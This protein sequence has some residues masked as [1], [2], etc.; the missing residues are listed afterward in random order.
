QKLDDIIKSFPKVS[1]QQPYLCNAANQVLSKAKD[2]MKPFGDEYVAIEHMLLAIL[3]GNDKT[4][5]LL[6]EQGIAAKI[7]SKGLKELGKGKFMTD[8]NAEHKHNP[9]KRYYKKQQEQAVRGNVVP[10][11]RQDEEI[12]RILQMLARRTRNN[13]NLIG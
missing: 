1:G 12:L 6:K 5:Q 2:Y 3:A 11:I 10:V 13:P 9:D 7:V 8:Q 4:A